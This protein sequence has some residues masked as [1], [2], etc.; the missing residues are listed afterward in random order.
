MVSLLISLLR[1]ECLRQNEKN[2]LQVKNSRRWVTIIGCSC[3]DWASPIGRRRTAVPATLAASDR[4]CS[5]QQQRWSHHFLD[6]GRRQATPAYFLS[7][8][9]N[10]CR[11][12]R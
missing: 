7:S 8:H 5:N 4:I 11:R 10:L 6:S 1:F 12:S 2:I 9:A 3:A